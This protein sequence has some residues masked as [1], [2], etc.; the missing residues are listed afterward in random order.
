MKGS[1]QLKIKKIVSSLS[2]KLQIVFIY[3]NKESGLLA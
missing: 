1:P 2:L 3:V